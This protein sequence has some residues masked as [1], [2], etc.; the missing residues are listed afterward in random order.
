MTEAAGEVKL[1]VAARALGRAGLA[2]AYGH[3]S[4]RLSESEFLVCAPVP[5]GQVPVGAAGTV[6]P[7]DGPLPEGVLGEVRIHQQLYKARPE[8]GGITRTMPPKIMA[9]SALG[10][11]PQMRHGMGAYFRAGIALWDSPLLIRDD[12]SAGALAAQMAGQRAGVMRGNGLVT[13]GESIEEAVVLAWYAED[14][15]RIELEVLG[16]GLDGPLVT[17]EEAEARDTWGGRI[18]DRMWDYLTFG[19]PERQG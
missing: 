17:P 7:V 10:R 2:H 8:A 5:M 1:R 9:L 3:C 11:V 19:D 4:V 16:T 14:A 6:V 18:M 12:A 15:A 13:V